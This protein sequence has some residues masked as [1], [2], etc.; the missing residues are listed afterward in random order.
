[1]TISVEELALALQSIGACTEEDL[2]SSRA[3]S[4]GNPEEVVQR[5]LQHL[6][7]TS[8]LTSFQAD[9]IQSGSWRELILGDYVLTGKIGEGGMGEVFSGVHRYLE[10]RVAIKRITR[11]QVE[12]PQLAERFRREMK[13]IAKLS[14]PNIVT[15]FDAGEKDGML[16]LV[17]EL[18][19]GQDLHS[20]VE[21]NGPLNVTAAV[22]LVLQ[23]ARGLAAVHQAGL[24]HR[25]IKPA[26]LMVD[27]RGTLKILDLGLAR[28]VQT[29]HDTDTPDRA[30]V[31]QAGQILGSVDYM[32]P[33][34]AFDTSQ[35]D[36]RT[37]VYSLGCC[38]HYLLLGK[39]I[40]GGDSLAARVVAH[41][42]NPV[43]SLRAER[44]DIPNGL[45]EAFARMVAKKP[46]QRY[47]AM[48]EVVEALETLSR[49]IDRDE[50]ELV[51]RRDTAEPSATDIFPPFVGPAEGGLLKPDG[52]AGAHSTTR[53]SE[54][55]TTV[56]RKAIRV[57]RSPPVLLAAAV[58]VMIASILFVGST[59]RNRDARTAHLE[60]GLSHESDAIA[61]VGATSATDQLESQDLPPVHAAFAP[62][63]RSALLATRQGEVSLISAKSGEQIL[64]HALGLSDVRCVSLLLDGCRCAI[65]LADGTLV[66]YNLQANQQLGSDRQ[67]EGPILC[68]AVSPAGDYL[69]SGGNDGRIGGWEID[70][71]GYLD[72]KQAHMA[73]VTAL[74]YSPDA[75]MAASGSADKTI[76]L[77]DMV[78]EFPQATLRG[79]AGTVT[80]LAF[81]SDSMCL[82][83]CSDTGEVASWD[84][85]ENRQ[86]RMSTLDGPLRVVVFPAG[87]RTLV[88]ADRNGQLWQEDPDDPIS[89]RMLGSQTA[90][91]VDLIPGVTQGSFLSIDVNGGIRRWQTD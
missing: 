41:S 2:R 79:H 19:D 58:I 86:I 33:E 62:D 6:I 75:K 34:Q 18:L 10:R 59:V 57:F 43:P 49:S 23:A 44:S 28:F 26:N 77:W 80:D 31:T 91:I 85:A 72:A 17:M 30:E 16:Y 73:P 69:L 81:S 74:V 1:M 20:V 50:S 65:G 22:D 40:Y 24:V 42:Q 82:A 54:S 47:S 11:R 78:D 7:A 21:R 87:S 90:A 63:G 15:A 60:E 71:D 29:T 67:H 68:L 12:L 55:P 52:R 53:L 83:S 89:L 51:S 56:G 84:V 27:P 35:V 32:S 64:R 76:V 45:D 4:S 70:G 88:C 36:G 38:M 46:N 48:T 13:T 5:C 9:E 8:R 3:D 39:P 37:D 66:L 25:D 14:H 61:S